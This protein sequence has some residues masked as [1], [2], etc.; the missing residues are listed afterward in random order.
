MK[1]AHILFLFIAM[2]NFGITTSPSN[3]F[4]KESL[5]IFYDNDAEGTESS[6]VKGKEMSILFNCCFDDSVVV[7][8]NDEVVSLKR[9]TTDPFV[10]LSGI[11]KVSLDNSKDSNML[12]IELPEAKVY[13]EI[14][15]DK[16]Y[17]LLYLSRSVKGEKKFGYIWAARFR[18]V[19]IYYY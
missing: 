5:K 4:T 16:N 14:S 1:T 6:N 10:S 3:D 15:L 18:N 17:K 12:R 11:V 19:P 13:S 2:L 7:Y 9:F 8:L